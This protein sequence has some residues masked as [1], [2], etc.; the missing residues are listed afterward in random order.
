VLEYTAIRVRD[1]DRSRRF[2]TDGLGL[3]P[4]GSRRTAT[5]GRWERLEDPESGAV[6]ELN[7]YPDS[8]AYR[9]GDELDHLAFRVDD[10]TAQVD[11]LVRLGGELRVPVTEEDGL[12]L[13][14]VS[15]PDG[16]WIKLFERRRSDEAPTSRP[17]E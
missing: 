2:Y 15:D 8:P 13:A 4:A 9:E 10:V 6:L 14:F 11:R 16:V 17:M 7:H 1:L 12:R 5:G 3:R